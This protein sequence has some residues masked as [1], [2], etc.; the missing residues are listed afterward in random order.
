VV[1]AVY[2]ILQPVIS[3]WARRRKQWWASSSYYVY[4]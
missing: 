3:Q 1:E 4:S 2:C